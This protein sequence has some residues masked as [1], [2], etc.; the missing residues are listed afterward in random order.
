M[1]LEQRTGKFGAYWGNTYDSSRSLTQSQMEVNAK[2]IYSYLSSEGWTLNAVAGILGNMQSESSINPGRWESDRVGGNPDV[3]GYG[4]VQ[5]TPYTKYTNWVSG[6]PSTMDN[7][8]SRILYE[9][10]NNIQWI[11]TSHY[12]YSFKSFTK[13][14]DTPYNL[15]LAFLA[16]YERPAD[17]VQPERGNQAEKWFEF[18]SGITPEPPEPPEPT[19]GT[20]KLKKFPWAV[21]T[22]IIRNRRTFF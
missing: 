11:A 15:A 2:Y 19:P 21:Y 12:N 5:W 13:S 3:H 8:I 18:L 6:D 7:N 17:P 20:R 1:G 9:V 4:L 14:N 16:N 22:K 10:D